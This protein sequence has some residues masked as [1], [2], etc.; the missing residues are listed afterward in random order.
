M[1][2][3]QPGGLHHGHLAIG[4]SV[5]GGEWLRSLECLSPV[6][7]CSFRMGTVV[8]RSAISAEKGEEPRPWKR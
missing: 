8:R 3:C 7:Q 1:Q 4:A 6:A 2:L 5:K